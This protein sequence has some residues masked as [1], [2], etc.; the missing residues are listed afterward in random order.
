MLVDSHCHLDRLDLSRHQDSLAEA[1]AAAEARDVKAFLCVCIDEG[2]RA[3]V[4]GIAEKYP[5]VVASV[6]THPC[7]VDDKIVSVEE[8]LTWADHPRVVA[9]GET[10]LDYHYSQ[11]LALAQQQSFTHHLLAGAKARLPV[12]V[13][14]REAKDDTL[15]LIREFGS[16]ESAGVLHCFTEDWPMARAAIELNYCISISGIVTFRN[17]NELRDVVKK[18]PLDHLLIETDSPYLAPIPHRGRP[19]VPQYV[20]DVAEYV[21]ELKGISLETLAEHT[22]R[23]FLRLFN[24]APALLP[25]PIAVA[26]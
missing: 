23:N 16:G 8:L 26:Q 19:N 5:N 14:T 18:V 13:H 21:A 2:N 3:D 1:L 20:R 10:G 12:I 17:A 25:D 7:H 6:G 11:E 15:N 9:L 24:R 4:L 22:T